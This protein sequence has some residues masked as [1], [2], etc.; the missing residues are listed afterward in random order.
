MDEQNTVDQPSGFLSRRRNKLIAGCGALLVGC[1]GLLIAIAIISAIT[2]DDSDDATATEIVAAQPTASDEPTA[3]STDTTEPGQPTNTPAPTNTSAPT[4]TPAPTNTPEP[5]ATPVPTTT[6][7][8][9]STPEPT[10]TETTSPTAT[11]VPEPK[12]Y[13]GSGTDVVDIEK[14]TSDM[15]AILYVRGNAAG[16]YFGVTGF[17]AAG[18]QNRLFVNTTD[19]FEG[20]V[21]LDFA[22]S[23]PTTRLQVEAEGDWYIEIRP[24]SSGR[25]VSKPGTIEGNGAEVIIVEEGSSTVAHIVGNPDGRYFGVIAYAD[26]S[27]LLVNTTDPFDGRVIVPSGIAAYEIAAIG[28]WSITFE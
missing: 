10:A 20:T 19:P 8:P 16:R 25:R 14:P 11:P 17:N 1:V 4:A 7:A 22:V 21:P 13:T 26:R 15:A 9:T 28:P 18:E 24:V 3:E 23:E 5:T 6:P 2:G 27:D 12:I